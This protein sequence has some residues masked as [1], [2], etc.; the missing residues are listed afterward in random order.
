MIEG[1]EHAYSNLIYDLG[2]ITACSVVIMMVGLFHSQIVNVRLRQL[3]THGSLVASTSAIVLLV[4]VPWLLGIVGYDTV[5]LHPSLVMGG[6]VSGLLVWGFLFK[7]MVFLEQSVEGEAYRE[8]QNRQDD[9]DQMGSMLDEKGTEI[10]SEMQG[11]LDTHITDVGQ[12]LQDAST[13]V[14]DAVDGK[15]GQMDTKLDSTLK[16]VDSKVKSMK[17]AAEASAAKIDG[18][19]GEVDRKVN[20]I[21]AEVSKNAGGLKEHVKSLE[22]KIDR[23]QNI[24]SEVEAIKAQIKDINISIGALADSL[25]PDED[26]VEEPQHSKTPAAVPSGQTSTTADQLTSKICRNLEKHGFRCVPGQSRLKPDILIYDRDNR[27][28]AP[29]LVRPREIP[30]DEENMTRR[31]S[32]K[33]CP[34]GLRFAEEHGVPLVIIVLN[35]KNKRLWMSIVQ[36]EN[37]KDWKGVTTPE[38]LAKN[39]EV[40]G[41]AL[42]REYRDAVTRLGGVV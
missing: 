24:P 35:T 16:D 7:W 22:A 33:M 6:L 11:K 27:L 9:V 5:W 12:K 21:K 36:F 39:D 15:L 17:D 19:K 20:E 23:I 8:R 1:Q 31:I 10:G 41:K 28:V 13:K 29:V 32:R 37:I 38:I 4:M 30:Y 2:V 34:V 18:F 14:T 40:S 3:V 26:P 42:E 25:L